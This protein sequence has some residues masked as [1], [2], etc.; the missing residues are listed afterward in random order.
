[1]HYCFVAERDVYGCD[2]DDCNGGDRHYGTK[3]NGMMW[4]D[5]VKNHVYS[6]DHSDCNKMR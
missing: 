3:V 6:C 1:M 4:C 5:V 2:H